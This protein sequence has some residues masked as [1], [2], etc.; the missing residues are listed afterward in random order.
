[1]PRYFF[2]IRDK[3]SF[4]SDEVGQEFPDLEAARAEALRD[5]KELWSDLSRDVARETAV[6]EIA[7]ETGETV[8]TVLFREA[9]ERP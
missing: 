8:L 9:G 6:I 3:N 2:H 5:A 7:D 4:K 1:M